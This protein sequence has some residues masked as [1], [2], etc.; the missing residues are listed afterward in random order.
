[1]STVTGQTTGTLVGL[2][3]TQANADADM[4]AVDGLIV[5]DSQLV[6]RYLG[7]AAAT[8]GGGIVMTGTISTA[9]LTSITTVFVTGLTNSTIA[10]VK[11]G[12]WVYGP[13]IPA[14]T[15]IL[16]VS[17]SGS[18]QLIGLSANINSR[19]PNAKTTFFCVGTKISGSF[20]K[21]GQLIVPGRG[22]LQIFPGDAVFVDNSGWPILIS[23]EA[24]A[25]V[26]SSW[27]TA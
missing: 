20:S 8:I 16:S 3:F 25:Y 17:G 14:G 24:L 10:S 15:K 21:N 12:Q 5:N 23:K 4:A 19:A 13:G 27:V 9:N 7:K 26:N 11:P 22:S 6:N 1:M 2:V 18:S